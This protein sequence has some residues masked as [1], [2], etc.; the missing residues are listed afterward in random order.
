MN[1]FGWARSNDC[2][3]LPVRSGLPLLFSRYP[4]EPEQAVLFFVELTPKLGGKHL[5]VPWGEFGMLTP[6]GHKSGHIWV[7][8][9][10]MRTE[11]KYCTV[12]LLLLQYCNVCNVNKLCC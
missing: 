5:D 2:K 3:T 1:E 7:E 9:S 11:Y 4:E 10:I 8:S 6:D 12:V